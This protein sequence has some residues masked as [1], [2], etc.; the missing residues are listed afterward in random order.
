MKTGVLEEEVL[1]PAPLPILFQLLQ[2]EEV[3][4]LI[5]ELTEAAA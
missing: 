2:E 1:A 4:L 5:T 3:N